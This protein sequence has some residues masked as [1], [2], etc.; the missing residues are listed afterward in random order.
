MLGILDL[1]SIG[2]YKI[3]QGMLQHNLS[4]YYRLESVNILCEQFNTFIN[5]LNKEKEQTKDR[6]PWSEQG[7]ERRKISDRETLY[8]YVD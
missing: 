8:K 4:K 7:N 6:Y 5:T 2:Y 3:K 1:R